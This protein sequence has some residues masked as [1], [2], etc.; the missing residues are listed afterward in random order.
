MLETKGYRGLD[1]QLKAST[2]QTMWVPGVNNLSA[3]GRW[4]FAEFQEVFAIQEEFG[5]LLDRFM[6]KEL[7]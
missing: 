7:G 2:M 6:I 4:A 3:H 5:R 1:A